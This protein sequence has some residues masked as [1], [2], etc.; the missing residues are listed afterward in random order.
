MQCSSRA[1]TSVALG[2]RPQ[3]TDPVT[4][5]AQ[6]AS[7][8]FYHSAMAFEPKL[9]RLFE[10]KLISPDVQAYLSAQSVKTLDDL[11]TFVDA[12]SDI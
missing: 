9:V 7:L 4:Q 5:T 12:Q 11:V 1:A 6:A 8:T 10:D 2:P 3:L